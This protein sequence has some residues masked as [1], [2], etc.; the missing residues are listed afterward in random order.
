MNTGKPLVG[1]A[2]LNKI[3][4]DRVM[5]VKSMQL[6]TEKAKKGEPISVVELEQCI[7]AIRIA[8][9]FVGWVF[10]DGSKEVKSLLR[11]NPRGDQMAKAQ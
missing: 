10:E 5:E 3:A 6:L 1:G 4:C 8:C 9:D 2:Q 7:S 11:A